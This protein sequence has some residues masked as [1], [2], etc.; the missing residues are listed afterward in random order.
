MIEYLIPAV[1][2]LIG[3]L[4]AFYTRREID[5]QLVE[6]GLTPGSTAAYVLVVLLWPVV[7]VGEAH[8]RLTGGA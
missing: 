8:G 4:M 5:R 6:N 2:V 3:S 7:I 1:Y